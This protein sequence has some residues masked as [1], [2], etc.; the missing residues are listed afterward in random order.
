MQAQQ[1]RAQPQTARVLRA[2]YFDGKAVPVGE[3][4]ELP[5]IFALEMKAANKIEF[6]DPPKVDDKSASQKTESRQRAI[7]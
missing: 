7:V 1:A 5:R 4:I 6:I 2:F 3:T